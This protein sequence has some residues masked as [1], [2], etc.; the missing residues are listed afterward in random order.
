MV[1][2]TE[3]GSPESHTRPIPLKDL[4]SH[5]KKMDT[6]EGWKTELNTLPDKQT[7][8]HPW[9]TSLLPEN[10]GKHRYPPPE[11]NLLTYDHT[12]VVLHKNKGDYFSDFI[13]ANWIETYDGKKRYIA[14]QGPL[15]TT[16]GDFYRMVH[17]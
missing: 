8:L 10:L 11:D 5:I 15:D 7:Q 17:E 2:E 16:I 9:N 4:E 13:N 12:R 3:T 6:S 14:T 1:A